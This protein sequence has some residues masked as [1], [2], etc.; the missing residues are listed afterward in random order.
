VF[1]LQ[2]G[3]K[4]ARADIARAVLPII[5]LPGVILPSKRHYHRVFQLYCTRPLGFADCYHVVLMRRLRL[6]DVFSFDTD[7]DKISGITRHE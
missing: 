5:D 2:R 6:K 1:S 4:L 7:F 3:Y